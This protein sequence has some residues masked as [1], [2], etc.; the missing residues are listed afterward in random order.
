VIKESLR[1]YPPIH[2]G[3]RR[4]AVDLQFRDRLIPAGTRVLYSIYLSHRDPRYWSEPDRFDPDRFAPGSK[5]KPEPFVYLPFGGGP[6]FCVGAAFAQT[7]AIVILARLLQ[8][9]EFDLMPAAVYPRMG[10]TLEPRPA[11]W[12]RAR[13]R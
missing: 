11:V 2:I 12:M 9:F 1:L 8:R 3:N 10:A 6:R 4:A 5:C 13:R 7:E